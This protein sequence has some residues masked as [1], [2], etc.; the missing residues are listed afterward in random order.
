MITDAIRDYA[1]ELVQNYQRQMPDFYA[2]KTKITF[3]VREVGDYHYQIVIDLPS[4]WKYI[5]RGRK[6]YPNP[7]D[8]RHNPPV[9]AIRKWI[10]VRHISPRNFPQFPNLTERG[11]PYMLS[12]LIRKRGIAPKP[13]LQNAI[14]ET[15]LDTLRANMKR[16]MTNQIKSILGLK[17]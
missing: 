14:N 15:N 6:A 12:N 8:K 16:E 17:Q 2:I 5:E 13:Y 1:A 9:E 10:Q 4:Y 11:L 3:D 7:Q